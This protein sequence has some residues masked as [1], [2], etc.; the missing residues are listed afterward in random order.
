MITWSSRLTRPGST[1]T[2]RSEPCNAPY[3]G[4]P[5]LFRPR[6]GSIATPRASSRLLSRIT[7]RRAAG[8]RLRQGFR[9]RRAYGG[10]DGARGGLPALP[11]RSD[12]AGV[13]ANRSDN[14]AHGI[15]GAVGVLHPPNGLGIVA[16]LAIHQ[17]TVMVLARLQRHRGPPNAV[18]GLAQVDGLL[19]PL[20]EISHQLH[21][22]CGRR[23][24]GEGL[25]LDLMYPCHAKF[26]S[27]RLLFVVACNQRS[28]QR[29]RVQNSPAPVSLCGRPGAV[30]EKL[31]TIC[32][33]GA[34]GQI[35]LDWRHRIWPQ[36]ATQSGDLPRFLL[37]PKRF[38]AGPLVFQSQRD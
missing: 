34:A 18:G 7:N 33:Q 27:F 6:S 17:E 1:L 13:M 24:E 32:S 23:G 2:R 14:L 37:N 16:P 11:A 38:V 12:A 10:Q 30:K 4:S 9:L 8:M 26:L 31:F 21:A 20:C 25:L 36:T 28:T 5:P 3:A 19:F 22:Q 15:L 29:I 35:G